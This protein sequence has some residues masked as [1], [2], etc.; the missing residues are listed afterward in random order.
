MLPYHQRK[1]ILLAH[2][3][4]TRYIIYSHFLSI[5]KRYYNLILYLIINITRWEGIFKFSIRAETLF[6]NKTSRFLNVLTPIPTSLDY[7]NFSIYH[8]K[9]REKN[10]PLTRL[11][12][13]IKSIS[14][15]LIPKYTPR[16]IIAWKT[17]INVNYET[18]PVC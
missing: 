10:I 5:T 1:F 17:I 16:T 6:R 8:S 14:A 18:M 11:R 2:S 13:S 4:R 12:E 15:T 3:I 9:Y 7:L